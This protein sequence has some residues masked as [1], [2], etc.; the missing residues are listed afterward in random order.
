MYD[1][2]ANTSPP[3]HMAVVVLSTVTPAL[4]AEWARQWPTYGTVVGLTFI[5]PIFLLAEWWGTARG[6]IAT[7]VAALYLMVL[8]P[9]NLLV[10]TAIVIC[11]S[12]ITMLIHRHRLLESRYA[13]EN[14]EI[15]QGAMRDDLTGLMNWHR[16]KQSVSTLLHQFPSHP[17][18]LLMIDI[19]Y[20]KVYNDTYGHVAGDR[21]L[22]E[23]AQVIS[24]A[25]PPE[26]LA[27]RYGGEEFAVLLPDFHTGQAFELAERLRKQVAGSSFPGVERM[28][29]QRLTVSIGV[30]SFPIH[31]QY[32]EQLIERADEALYLAKEAGRNC[33]ISSRG[34]SHA[35]I[36][37]TRITGPSVN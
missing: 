32:P 2:P 9:D 16:F 21:L 27:F 35:G 34:S 11:G 22:A 15:R 5:L 25:I 3:W 13:L 23:V 26:C 30:A 14:Q 8:H 19:D 10:S 33:V 36:Q 20:F 29:E 37:L 18:S 6:W 31:A 24:R 28:P 4:A 12:A 7:V 17:L 1:K